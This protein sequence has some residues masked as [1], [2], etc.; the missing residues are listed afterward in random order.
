MARVITFSNA[1]EVAM[2]FCRA[3]GIDHTD[4]TRMVID[5][6]AGEIGRIYVEHVATENIIAPEVLQV[7]RHVR[8]LNARYSKPDNVD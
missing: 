4:V 6:E 5:L 2:A 8:I 7:L 1:D 3:I